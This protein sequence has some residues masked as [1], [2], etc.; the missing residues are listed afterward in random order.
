MGSMAAEPDSRDRVLFSVQKK[1][2]IEKLNE[3]DGRSIEKMV[4]VEEME[5]VLDM[6]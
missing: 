6:D 5:L 1:G 3:W 4:L 2:A